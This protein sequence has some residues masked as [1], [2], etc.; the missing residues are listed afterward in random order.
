[1]DF[2]GRLIGP[3]RLDRV[4]RDLKGG[5]PRYACGL[6]KPSLQAFSFAGSSLAASELEVVLTHTLKSMTSIPHAVSRSELGKVRRRNEDACGAHL[7]A[8]VLYVAD[9]MGGH[10]AGHVASR[11]AARCADQAVHDYLDRAIDDPLH[12]LAE[13]IQNALNDHAARHELAWGLGTTFTAVHRLD[14]HTIDVLHI[15]DSRAYLFSKRELRPITEDHS[16]VGELV[17]AG[18]LTRE[19]A[20]VHPES[21]VISQVLVGD[22][23]DA[24]SYDR[25]Q[26]QVN[27][28]ERLV[29]CTD[30]LSDMVAEADIQQL[31]REFTDLNAAADALVAEALHAGGRDNIT[32]ILAEL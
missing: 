3:T 13:T 23:R 32:F 28:G 8:G 18:E 1:V 27:A 20:R 16:Y 26:L 2:D 6:T 4:N 24:D 11:I 29:L 22:G 14:E 19:Q 7:E 31:L 21:H 30:G 25:F 12:G 9:G 10:P 5:D 15:G 17:R